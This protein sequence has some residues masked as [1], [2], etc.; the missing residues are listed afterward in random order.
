MGALKDEAEPRAGVL[1]KIAYDPRLANKEHDRALVL[2]HFFAYLR[3]NP[4][5][6]PDVNMDGF[7]HW[8][9]EAKKHD[10]A[11]LTEAFSNSIERQGLSVHSR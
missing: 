2:L 9:G 3:R 8:V 10:A 4:D 1:L 6:P 11:Y 5:D 7:L